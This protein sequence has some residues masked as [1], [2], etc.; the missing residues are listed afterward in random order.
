M[1]DICFEISGILD[2]QIKGV[3]LK[4]NQIKF[5]KDMY[6]Y[7]D[8]GCGGPY[9]AGWYNDLLFDEGKETVVADVHTQPTGFGGGVVGN[10]LHVGTGKVNLGVFLAKGPAPDNLP[11]AFV[12]PVMS[13]YETVTNNFQRYNDEEWLSVLNGLQRPDWTSVYLV[14]KEGAISEK[15]RELPFEIVKMPGNNVEFFSGEKILLF[16]NPA[17]DYL[18]ISELPSTECIKIYD[19]QG[20]LVFHSLN[21]SNLIDLKTFEKGIYII[22]IVNKGKY[23]T[24][25]FIKE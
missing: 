5:L 12:G 22:K 6:A 21:N 10:V 1:R 16:P 20:R 13:Y 24:G 8:G 19:L 9:D 3:P 23:Y 4:A 17:G 25:K 7:Q 15:G 14:N 11:M 2:Y 18:T